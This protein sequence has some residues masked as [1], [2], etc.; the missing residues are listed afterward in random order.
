MA[1]VG[2]PAVSEPTRPVP[3]PGFASLGSAANFMTIPRPARS[4]R[5]VFHP[6]PRGTWDHAAI[7]VAAEKLRSHVSCRLAS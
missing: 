1:S 2:Y 4:L 5:V 7:H 3:Q 6:G